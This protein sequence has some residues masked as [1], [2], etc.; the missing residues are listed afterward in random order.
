MSPVSG[1]RLLIWFLALNLHFLWKYPWIRVLHRCSY[2]NLH[3]QSSVLDQTHYHYSVA[4]QERGQMVRLLWAHCSKGAH[5][6]LIC[7]TEPFDWNH[8]FLLFSWMFW[9]EFL[10]SWLQQ[11]RVPTAA[12]RFCLMQQIAAAGEL[13]HVCIVVD[14]TPLNLPLT[15]PL[16]LWAVLA[17]SVLT[18]CLL[19]GCLSVFLNN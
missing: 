4:K 1:E 3:P 16:M 13:W 6:G 5:I 18:V 2:S 14:S 10:V 11:I 17:A 7:V 9:I 15:G 8:A 19:F 12:K